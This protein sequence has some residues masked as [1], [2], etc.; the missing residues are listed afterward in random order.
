MQTSASSVVVCSDLLWPAVCCYRTEKREKCCACCCVSSVAVSRWQCHSRSRSCGCRHC[1]RYTFTFSFPSSSSV[2]QILQKKEENVYTVSHTGAKTVREWVKK[3]CKKTYVIR[4][5]W[6]KQAASAAAAVCTVVPLWFISI[7]PRINALELISS[8]VKVLSVFTWFS[9]WHLSWLF[10]VAPPSFGAHVFR[11]SSSLCLC[12]NP[13]QNPNRILFSLSPSAVP[14]DQ[15]KTCV[16]S[17]TLSGA[18]GSHTIPLISLFSSFLSTEG[19]LVF[20]FQFHTAVASSSTVIRI[21]HKHLALS[22]PAWLP[23]L[24]HHHTRRQLYWKRERDREERMF[25]L[26]PY[27]SPS[28][29]RWIAESTTTTTLFPRCC[30]EFSRCFHLSEALTPAPTNLKSVW[31]FAAVLFSSHHHRLQPSFNSSPKILPPFTTTFSLYKHRQLLP[32]STK[33]KGKLFFVPHP[34]LSFPCCSIE[35]H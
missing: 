27:S 6:P 16:V 3:E 7:S 12:M 34:F 17:L 33:A 24:H 1:H 11:K 10:T 26:H 18:K 8:T 31:M 13:S 29:F 4:S 28:L 15:C 30:T 23:R 22:L 5:R 2:V 32:V 25:Y 19:V 35:I 9:F 21:C 14:E 20:V